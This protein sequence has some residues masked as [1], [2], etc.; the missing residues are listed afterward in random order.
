M[1]GQLPPSPKLAGSLRAGEVSAREAVEASLARIDALDPQLNAFLCVQA[2]RA[3]ARARELDEGRE[4]GPLHGIP[5]GVKDLIDVEG[6]P[7]TAASRILAGNVARES[8]TVVKRLEAAGAVIVGKLNTHEFAYGALTTSPHFGPARNPWDPGRVCG[9]SSGGS[10]AAPAA[11]LVAGALGSDTAGSVRIPAAFCGIS[12]IRPSTGLVPCR[13][14]L[15]LAWS[16]DAVGPMARTAEDCALLLGVIAGHD[17]AD[18]Q[19]VPVEVQP[20]AELL[21]GDIR[22][23]RI[24]AVRAFFEG[25][26]DPRVAAS[27]DGSL[28][29][30]RTLGASVEPVELPFLEEARLAQQAIQFPEATSV[31]LPWLRTRLADYGPDVRIRALAGLHWPPTVYVTGQR[32]R[33]LIAEAFHRVFERFDLL[34]QPAMPMIA[35]RLGETG[36]EVDGLEGLG[37]DAAI[38]EDAYRLAA[39][40]YTAPWSLVGFP[41]AAVPCGVVA[42]MPVGLS[43]VGPRLADALVLRAA[44]A[45]QRVTDWHERLPPG[46]L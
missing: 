22:G 39:I 29:E 31:H 37:S 19:S 26:I 44:H 10:G 11:G 21:A 6:M 13:G 2:D 17:P 18:P 1:P 9:G 12:G 36:I 14:V 43:L 7:T 41:A 45:F 46:S 25:T 32:A 33:R 15:P 40:R 4:R 3:L 24:G 5:L 20:Y 27:V 42:G 8:A 35:P 23:L 38:G 16:F 34:V 28:A 30:L